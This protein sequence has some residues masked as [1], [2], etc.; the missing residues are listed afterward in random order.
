[1][2]TEHKL[3]A[4]ER[5]LTAAMRAIQKAAVIITHLKGE[6]LEYIKEPEECDE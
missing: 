5:H 2:T 1:M 3:M 4:A 6:Q